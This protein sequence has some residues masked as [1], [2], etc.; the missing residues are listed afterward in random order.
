MGKLKYFFLI[1][2]Q[3]AKKCF[4]CQQD[5]RRITHS[6]AP[7]SLRKHTLLGLQH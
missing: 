5:M 4:N 3:I 6:M 2:A 1:Y 7:S